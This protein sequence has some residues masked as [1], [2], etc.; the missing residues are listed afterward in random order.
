MVLIPEVPGPGIPL[1]GVGNHLRSDQTSAPE[2]LTWRS[3]PHDGNWA[4]EKCVEHPFLYALLWAQP[5]TT[6]SKNLLKGKNVL[7]LPFYDSASGHLELIDCKAG[8]G[9]CLRG[10][11]TLVCSCHLPSTLIPSW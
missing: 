2:T 8:P 5:T 10:E 3:S 9:N 4:R 7:I 6:T 1:V 11:E